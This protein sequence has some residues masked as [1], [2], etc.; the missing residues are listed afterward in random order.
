MESENGMKGLQILFGVYFFLGIGSNA[1]A[2]AKLEPVRECKAVSIDVTHPIETAKVVQ[3]YEKALD[4]TTFAY[5][6]NKGKILL[7]IPAQA[8]PGSNGQEYK[9]Y[10][11]S[12]L[13]IG[14]LNYDGRFPRVAQHSF[15]GSPYIELLLKD[16]VYIGTAQ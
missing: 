7:Y 8:V 16:C 14:T 5:T 3:Y 13:E 11:S 4:R 9:L 15:S 2:V 1:F 10:N 6:D 12:G